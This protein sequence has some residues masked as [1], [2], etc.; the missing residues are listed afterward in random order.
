MPPLFWC[1][2]TPETSSRRFV[3]TSSSRK[4]CRP[5]Q[6][7]LLPTTALASTA[8]PAATAATALTTAAQPATVAA[9]ALAAVTEPTA[10]AAAAL[11]AA[12]EPAK[13]AVNRPDPG[14]VRSGFMSLFLFRL[15]FRV[16]M[17]CAYGT[18]GK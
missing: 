16:V 3:S 9:S 13:R 5:S 12:A 7:R 18:S 14:V 8:H 6:A 17:S 10:L 4:P 15:V 2:Y 11:A 1:D